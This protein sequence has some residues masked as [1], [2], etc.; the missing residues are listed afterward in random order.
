M[1]WKLATAKTTKINRAATA[2]R[3][4]L[5]H[6]CRDLNRWPGSWMGLKQDLPLGEQ[7][8]MLSV[9]SW[10]ILVASKLSP[11][12]IHKHVDKPWALGGKFICDLRNDLSER[13]SGG[14]GDCRS[15]T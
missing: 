4:E 14:P 10:N 3:H 2:P 11:K 1:K 9:R 5:E 12:T 6:Y 13:A 8:L 15:K 7:L